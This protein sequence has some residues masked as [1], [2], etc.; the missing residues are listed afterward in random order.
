MIAGDPRASAALDRRMIAQLQAAQFD[1]A[2][3]FTVYSQNPLP[4]ALLCYLADIP[5]RLGHCRE[6]QYK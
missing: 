4:A 2:I 3:V 1:A 6:N 5:L